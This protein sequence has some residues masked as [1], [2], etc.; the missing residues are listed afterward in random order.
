[1]FKLLVC[2]NHMCSDD[3]FNKSCIVH[4][5]VVWLL[6]LQVSTNVVGVM[7]QSKDMKRATPQLVQ[8][9]SSNHN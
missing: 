2:E 5:H 7:S 4:E 6:K 8:D 1:M 3:T 9:L